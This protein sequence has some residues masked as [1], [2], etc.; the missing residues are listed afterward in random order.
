MSGVDGLHGDATLIFKLAGLALHNGVEFAAAAQPAVRG[1]SHCETIRHVQKGNTVATAFMKAVDGSY[2]T[3][4]KHFTGLASYGQ[5]RLEWW[6]SRS[7]TGINSCA[8]WDGEYDTGNAFASD[9]AV[10]G[11]VMN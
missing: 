8:E 9:E 3:D 11:H 7:I 1:R 10:D 2:G 6:K 4:C 5:P